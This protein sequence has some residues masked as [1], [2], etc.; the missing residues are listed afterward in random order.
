MDQ[1]LPED[2]LTCLAEDEQG[3][4]WI[5]TRQN[6]FVIADPKTG[7]RAYGD[8]QR[9]GLPDNF[10]TKLLMLKDG[11]YLVGFYGGGVVKPIK[12]YKLVDRKP[13]RKFGNINK[14][15]FSV[16]QNDFKDL[17]SPIAPPTTEDILAMRKKIDQL[18]TRIPKIYA[19]YCGE[20]WKTQGDWIGRKTSS[21]AI[22]CAA[23]S[24]DDQRLVTP[25]VYELHEFIGPHAD[26][27]DTIRRWLHWIKTDNPRSLWNPFIGIRR[28]AEWDDHG[29]AYSMAKDGPDLW[30][31][32]DVKEEGM[33]THR[34][35]FFNKDG[36]G[37][38]NRFR[39]YVIEIYATNDKFEGRPF[40]V[41]RKYSILAERV[42]RQQKPL[43]KSRVRNF[44]GGVYK[45]FL[46]P[47]GK[48][49]V[50]IRRNYSFN[51]IVSAVILDRLQGKRINIMESLNVYISH[52]VSPDNPYLISPLPFPKHVDSE[53]GRV[54]I[55]TWNSL[56]E[57]YNRKGGM[58]RQRKMRLD[59][60]R[61][62]EAIADDDENM[63]QIRRVLK[64]R[65]NI[66]DESQRKEWQDTMNKAFKNLYDSNEDLQ[67]G[68]KNNEL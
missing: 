37:G 57:T 51:T 54:I 15:T 10:V 47:K 55:D 28:Q 30:Y 66:W 38:N 68:I 11:D 1:L 39:D 46:L 23:R 24:P 36:H 33:F 58:E 62:S 52:Y 27:N 41:W 53:I 32:I 22:M 26:R 2:Y 16:A 59:L 42:T 63:S 64:W 12:P 20:D 4:I 25:G 48:Y 56:D 19:S 43:V 45:E 3:V 21:W 29:E 6:G 18:K 17:P 8:P 44:W 50:K 49:Y 31:W 35:Y 40:D 67:K 61:K 13:A 7:K 34:A 9:M 65:L 14:P 60:F 5:G